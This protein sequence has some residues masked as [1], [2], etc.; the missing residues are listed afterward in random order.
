[1]KV[2]VITGATSG[3]GRATTFALARCGFIVYA[4]SR[5][6]GKIAV[7][8]DEADTSELTIRTRVLDVTDHGRF[9]GFTREV[10]GEAG[11][12]D[13]LINNAG[14]LQVGSLEDLSEARL[15]QVME[16]NFFGPILLTKSMLEPMRNQGFGHIIMISSLSGLA[17]LPGESA[18]AAS[19]FALEG[20]TEALR[21][22]MKPWNIKV[23]LIEAGSY[24]TALQ[25]ES[26][27][28]ESSNYSQMLKTRFATKPNSA[29][30]PEQLADFIIDVISSDEDRLRWPADATAQSV[31]ENLLKMDDFSRS[32]FLR[33]ISGY[34]D[35][36]QN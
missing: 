12:V 2:A 13:L 23:A 22:E 17:G 25:R 20:A 30:E 11:R 29:F 8:Q 1:M 10:F 7:L 24:K 4:T 21:L 28:A 9:P 34:V 36:Q 35:W 19:K 14:I 5:D 31:M 27:D 18:Y 32:A 26:F 6:P 15:R 16:T 3:I 33:E